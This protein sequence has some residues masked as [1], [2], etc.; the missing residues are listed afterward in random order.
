MGVQT[1]QRCVTDSLLLWGRLVP[2]GVPNFHRHTVHTQRQRNLVSFINDVATLRWKARTYDISDSWSV[3]SS[4]CGGFLNN[5][6]EHV[7]V[8]PSGK[9]GGSGKGGRDGDARRN[10][11]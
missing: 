9:R 4:C 5:D 7:N 2:V 6:A 3:G 1:G 11:S 10:W 8:D